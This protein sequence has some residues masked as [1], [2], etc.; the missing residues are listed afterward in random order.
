MEYFS[1]T[2][3]K[4]VALERTCVMVNAT[5]IDDAA[6]RATKLRDSGF[7]SFVEAGSTYAVRRSSR[8]E[9][10]L[11]QKFMNS[12]NRTEAK[13]HLQSD[14]DGLLARRQSLM[15]SFFMAL[16]LAPDKIRQK[17]EGT[18]GSSPKPTTSPSGSGGSEQDASSSD[19]AIAAPEDQA[20]SDIQNDSLNLDAEASEHGTM[21]D[22][23][24]DASA[25]DDAL[26]AILGSAEA[27]NG[28]TKDHSV[29]L[30]DDEIF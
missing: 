4:G 26:A 25:Q 20:S 6:L 5:N 3:R 22:D 24:I 7:L 13:I 17:I 11:L 12:C 9:T 21:G 15:M 16:Y 27:N 28:G 29:D 18:E 1:L 14:F 10:Q 19:K 30:G 8:K 23:A 2:A